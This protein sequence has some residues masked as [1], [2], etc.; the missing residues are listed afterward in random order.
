MIF[1]LICLIAYELLVENIQ[2]AK[3]CLQGLRRLLESYGGL[4]KIC[5][6]GIT[7]SAMSE[8]HKVVRGM[9]K[10]AKLR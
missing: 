9:E 3:T 1:A 7:T 4:Q 8:M 6:T 2:D 10:Y 5:A